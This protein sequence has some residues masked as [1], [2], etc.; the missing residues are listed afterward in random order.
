MACSAQ[1]SRRVEA[2]PGPP[3]GVQ[4]L[5]LLL[6]ASG[7]LLVLL[8]TFDAFLTLLHPDRDGPVTRTVTRGVWRAAALAARA[9]PGRREV[10]AVAGPAMIV[11]N[12]LSWAALLILG[13][14]LMVWPALDGYH[15]TLGADLGFTEALYFS[16]ATFTT[17]GYGD[18][19]PVD[20]PWQLLAIAESL[21]GFLVMTTSIAYILEVFG[22]I[23]HRDTVAL[24]IYS[25]TGGTWSG[26]AFLQR[27]H[28]RGG[29]EAVSAR[30]EKWADLVRE[31]HGRLY[32]FHGLAF[33]L[34]TQG[35]RHGP[36]RMLRAIAEATL[37]ANLLAQRPSMRALRVP[38]DELA[39]AFDHL[40]R[41]IVRRQSTRREAR[42]V[43]E[44]TPTR[45]DAE[46]L[47]RRERDLVAELGVPAA[48]ADVATDETLLALAARTRAFLAHVDAFALGT[49]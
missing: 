19:T 17:L 21:S 14:A 15:S 16:G 12:V 48:E 2:S 11:T 9:L 1:P 45:E 28:A 31:L 43:D 44:A 41:A 27:A 5:D 10:L 32:R 8:G 38:A 23:D 46:M 33:Y 3:A 42:R 29:P 4:A 47:R 24:R 35:L 26:R 36:E 49:R 13:Y 7:A 25:E 34:R 22:G 39:R 18:L 20:W 37:D 6:L 30:V 40:A